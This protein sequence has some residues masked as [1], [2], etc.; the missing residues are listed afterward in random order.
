MPPLTDEQ[1][2]GNVIRQWISG[3]SR[4]TI[5]EQ[6]NIGAGTVSSIVANYKVGLETLDLN[7]IRKLSIEISKQGLNWLD[8]AS[9]FKLYNYFRKSGAAEEDIESFIANINS[10]DASPE[11]LIKLVNESFN[12]SKSESIPLDQV[13]GYI[14]EK[15]EEKQKIDEEIK[16][17]DA[18][19]QSKNVSIEAINEHIQLN[20]ELKNY[21]L[22]TKDVHSS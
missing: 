5:A 9:N 13:T 10:G 19:L 20:E 6:N 1:T 2:R 7:S 4:D 18:L 16:E 8:L 11:N 3:F 17:A 12:I 22:S 15:L 21:G 14:K